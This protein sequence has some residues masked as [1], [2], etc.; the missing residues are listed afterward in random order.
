[1]TLG[2]FFIRQEQKNTTVQPQLWL[3]F[4]YNYL[5]VMIS[6]AIFQ[7]FISLFFFSPKRD[8]TPVLL[9]RSQQYH[10]TNKITTMRCPW[11]VFK[12]FQVWRRVNRNDKK[13]RSE[14]RKILPFTLTLCS[15]VPGWEMRFTCIDTSPTDPLDDWPGD[16]PKQEN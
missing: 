6:S 15:P 8:T 11:W 4:L 5:T 3:L 2:L 13:S 12:C 1:M 7:M 9:I 10:Q 16:T 14:Y